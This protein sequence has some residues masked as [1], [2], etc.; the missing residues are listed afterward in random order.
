MQDVSNRKKMVWDTWEFCELSAI[1]YLQFFC[2]SKLAIKI[3]Y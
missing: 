3:V 1:Q 2:K